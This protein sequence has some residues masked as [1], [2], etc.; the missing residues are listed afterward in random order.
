MK[1]KKGN[2]I[3]LLSCASFFIFPLLLD[4]LTIF[5]FILILIS[6]II[7]IFFLLSLFCLLIKRQALTVKIK[8]MGAFIVFVLVF[9][10]I[11]S[12]AVK[13]DFLFSRDILKY[14]YPIAQVDGLFSRGLFSYFYPIYF[15]VFGLLG[16]LLSLVWGK[17]GFLKNNLI[18]KV[19]IAFFSIFI[20]TGAGFS[21]ANGVRFHEDISFYFREKKL[22][23]YC[24]KE[25]NLFEEKYRDFYEGKQ[26]SLGVGDYD[27]S[28]DFGTICKEDNA[29]G[30]KCNE[31]CVGLMSDNNRSF[32]HCGTRDIY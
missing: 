23:I 27:S 32:N 26:H 11:T 3:Y 29:R 15:T 16:F 9:F 20:L 31:E 28:L 5:Y 30:G 22:K 8:G 24:Q 14:P 7:L 21:V 1:N 4:C 18:K 2:G 12:F 17:I 13:I 19:V 6:A 25:L 10:I